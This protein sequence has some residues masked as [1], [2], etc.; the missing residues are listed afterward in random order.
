MVISEVITGPLP[1]QPLAGQRGSLEVLGAETGTQPTGI[2]DLG[3]LPVA[4]WANSAS[5]GRD[6]QA[7]GYDL[8]DT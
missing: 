8:R 1:A 4:L 2:E 6:G 3:G 5:A 7:H